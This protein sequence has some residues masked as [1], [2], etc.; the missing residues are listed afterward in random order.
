M[1]IWNLT[2]KLSPLI[3]LHAEKYAKTFCYEFT[4]KMYSLPF[5]A[6]LSVE[7]NGNRMMDMCSFLRLPDQDTFVLGEVEGCHAFLKEMYA[8]VIE[9]SPNSLSCSLAHFFYHLN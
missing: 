3:C 6:G 4:F 9:T 5:D 8:L 2:K 7:H 1:S